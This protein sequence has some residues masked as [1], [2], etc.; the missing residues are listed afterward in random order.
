MKPTPILLYLFPVLCE[1]VNKTRQALVF[2]TEKDDGTQRMYAIVLLYSIFCS[3]FFPYILAFFP[4]HT[5][6]FSFE[7]HRVPCYNFDTTKK[8]R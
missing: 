4:Y 1:P 2:L 6:R 3:A 7:Q 8:R 5:T